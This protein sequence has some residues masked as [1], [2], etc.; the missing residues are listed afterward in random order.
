MKAIT[1]LPVDA[2]TRLAAAAG[3]P[4]ALVRAADDEH[5]R[6]LLST[7]SRSM[8]VL[9]P[10][11]VT[12]LPVGDVVDSLVTTEAR[13]IVYTSLTP[14]G[15][16]AALPFV[17]AHAAEVVLR[18][19]DDG[20]MRLQHLLTV[21]IRMSVV[22]RILAL[23]Q[24]GMTDLPPRLRDC[25]R[26]MFHD[27]SAIDSSKRLA[28]AANMTRRSLDRWID[29][30]GI[31]SVRLLVAAPKVLRAYMY[32]RQPGMS[33]AR[34][35]TLLG[36]SSSRPLEQHCQVL[37]GTEAGALREELSVNTVI[38]RIA[39]RLLVKSAYQQEQ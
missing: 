7:M 24:P 14:D 6:T 17:R 25:I 5:L 4:A 2:F 21:G 12:V 15:I 22:E 26:N 18:G 27:N 34:A 31:A 38:T 37:L 28:V 1:L 39:D 16:Q 9:D 23:L 20:L 10:K 33:V 36:F 13:V 35:A 11:L 30:S 8:V 3:G 19:Y 32:L 29:R